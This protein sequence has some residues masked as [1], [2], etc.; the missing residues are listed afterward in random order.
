MLDNN[1]TCFTK[2]D[3]NFRYLICTQVNFLGFKLPKFYTLPPTYVS[4]THTKNLKLF[5]EEKMQLFN[6]L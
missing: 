3:L 1:K 5:N 4:E 2:N 6:T